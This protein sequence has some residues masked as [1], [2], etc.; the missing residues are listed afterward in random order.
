[1]NKYLEFSFLLSTFALVLK[2]NFP[3]LLNHELIQFPALVV[4]SVVT[5]IGFALS[6]RIYF[7]TNRTKG[8]F[9]FGVYGAINQNPF[10]SYG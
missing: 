6:L 4:F 10:S 8:I 5:P 3:E 9:S 2:S 7:S 1:M